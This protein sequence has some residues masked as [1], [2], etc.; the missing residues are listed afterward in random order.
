M[1][2]SSHAHPLSHGPN[3]PSTAS[4]SSSHLSCTTISPPKSTSQQTINESPNSQTRRLQLR[5]SGF[6]API[7]PF[8]HISP[9]LGASAG[10][11]EPFTRPANNENSPPSAQHR[12]T[13][14]DSPPYNPVK[15]MEEVQ[16]MS[17][18]KRRISPRP[19]FGQI[20]EDHSNQENGCGTSWY[21]EG[22]HECSPV[23]PASTPARMTHLREISLNSA[24]TPPLVSPSVKH[25]KG[26]DTGRAGVRSASSEA[27]QYIEHLESEL[28][29]AHAKLD[30]QPSPKT[31]KLRAAKLRNLTTENHT[32][33]RENSE[34][35]KNFESRV[36][37]EK[38][39]LV[40]TDLELRSGMRMLE[41]EM[42]MKDARLSELEWELDSMRVRMRDLEGLEV[43]NHNL[44]KRIEA[45]TNLLVQTPTKI[46]LPSASISP[47]RNDLSKRTPRPRSMF[48][49]LPPSPGGLRTMLPT[50][51]ES[52]Y[53]RSQSLGDALD[54]VQS[55]EENL[56]PTPGNNPQSPIGKECR[57]SRDL[58]RHSGSC[59]RKSRASRAYR[60]TPSSASKRTSVRSSCSFGPIA[61]GLPD[62]EHS[63][64]K[65]RKMRRFPSG[66]N[67]L[68][69]LILPCATDVPSTPTS[70]AALEINSRG[71]RGISNISLD[72]ASTF[73]SPIDHDSTP[74]PAEF[75]RS[76]SWTQ[77][78]TLKALEGRYRESTVS[79]G[80]CCPMSLSPAPD[81]EQKRPLGDVSSGSRKR[82]SRPRSLQKELEDAEVE[83]SREAYDDAA[84]EE[85]R[86]AGIMPTE[87]R[88]SCH[89]DIMPVTPALKPLKPSSL[90]A[91][92]PQRH[93][94]PHT[95][96]TPR[97]NLSQLPPVYALPYPVKTSPS[98]ELSNDRAHGI[99]YR[100]TNIITKTKQDP[101]TLARRLLANAWSSSRKTL[102]GIGWWLIGLVYGTRHWRKPK[103]KADIDTA[104]D[105]S[106]A[107]DFDWQHF[108]AQASR[109]GAGEHYFR[110]PVVMGN[111]H[112]E[113][114]LEPR[115]VTV[116]PPTSAPSL[117]KV[118][119]NPH[120]FP[121]DQCVEPSSRRTLRLWLQFS[122]T[123]IL[124]VGMAVKHGPA[125]LLGSDE[126]ECP[127]LPQPNHAHNGEREPLLSLPQRRDRPRNLARH[128]SDGDSVPSGE[129]RNS[130]VDSGYGS[131]VFAE[132]LG[133]MDFEALSRAGT[134]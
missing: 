53:G 131:I 37:E 13:H 34:W 96:T 89:I 31:S 24:R 127:T 94:T 28:A 76:A 80:G 18:K 66:L 1:E 117:Q 10:G 119:G 71:R 111:N 55:P 84:G 99:F 65:S 6:R 61:W 22:S 118:K 21:E 33:K 97:P 107:S 87:P 49:K 121:C 110:D 112:R 77:E 108:S 52:S 113:S 16:K 95:D 105:D 69:P 25:V 68:K 11:L 125:A 19:G 43:I 35:H 36:Q 120:L 8:R 64:T 56:S 20:F 130:N 7:L 83:Q 93:R 44:E 79:D 116:A 103:Q 91:H 81:T 9:L 5:N 126:E 73:L 26:R 62:H 67:T 48:P 100:L 63:P 129:S 92:D 50:V 70:E 45:L 59:D 123:I 82:R 101:L 47:V 17:A 46:E 51:S 30:L 98:T 15:I 27:A 58:R 109:S 115:R 124:A 133:P 85:R 40:D 86:Q 42:E 39:K 60:S 4:L 3:S 102:G 54:N 132:T 88:N 12:S 41:D 104:S 106:S 114:W 29:S 78:Q 134:C 122:L 74:E 23:A 90:S 2:H 75:H 72:P 128:C 57:S 32:L 38:N 14:G